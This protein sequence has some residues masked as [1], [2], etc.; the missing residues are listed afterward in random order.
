MR[1]ALSRFSKAIVIGVLGCA[2]A[3]LVAC[4]DSNGLLPGDRAS[5]L[6]SALDGVSAACAR[7]SVDDAEAAVARVQRQVDG[8][9]SEDVDPRLIRNLRDGV[10]TIEE[11]IPDS[12]EEVSTTV[13]TQTE[14]VTPPVDT[15][16]QQETPPQTTSTTPSDGGGTTTTPPDTGG[17]T[18]TPPDTGGGTTPPDS[19]GG[20]TPPDSGGGTAPGSDVPD[21]NQGTPGGALAPGQGGTTP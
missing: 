3:I 10:G 1:F 17:G 16:P 9:S 2:A 20:A 18:T 14:V 21:V 19:G 5:S 8:L 6:D 13:E 15:T 11:L 12:C 7:G 4:G